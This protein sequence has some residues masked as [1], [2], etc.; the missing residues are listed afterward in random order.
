MNA[1]NTHI[2]GVT[3]EFWG[4]V[5]EMGISTPVDLLMNFP[6]KYND[7]T[8]PLTSLADMMGNC[9]GQYVIATLRVVKKGAIKRKKGRP[10][11]MT[12][13]LTDG[14]QNATATIFGGVQAWKD[15]K[16]LDFVFIRGKVDQWEGMVSFK[17]AMLIP[18][19]DHNRVAPVYTGKKDVMTPETLR[20]NT[21]L[22]LFSNVRDAV[23]HIE[24]EMGASEFDMR[25]E[26]DFPYPNLESYLMDVHMPVDV[27]S[28]EKIEKASQIINCYQLYN[29][30][31]H[32]HTLVRDMRSVIPCDEGLIQK[33]A[34]R[35]P[36]P[37]T[38]SQR[39]GIEEMA[40]LLAANEPMNAI[41]QGD[42]G[43]GKTVPYLTLAVMAYFFGKRVAIFIPNI[44]L[45]RQVADELQKHHSDVSINLIIDDEKHPKTYDG[46]SIV[47][48]TSAVHGWMKKAGA[49]HVFDFVIV[50]EQ[51]KMSVSQVNDLCSDYTN[52][53]EATATPVP[54][55]MALAAFG[56][57]K[58]FSLKECPVKKDIRSVLLTQKSREKIQ[59]K[60]IETVKNGDK[61]AIIY[62]SRERNEHIY[63][64][65]VPHA[66]LELES[67]KGFGAK[68]P[69]FLMPN[70]PYYNPKE[71][72]KL[73][74][75][76]TPKQ[77][78]VIKEHIST[79]YDDDI[80]SKKTDSAPY[81]TNILN[82]RNV[83]EAAKDWEKQFPGKVAKLHGGM[84]AKEKQEVIRKIADGTYSFIVS[85]TVIEVGM[86]FPGLKLLVTL[87]SDNYGCNTLHQLRGRIARDGG[88]GLFI[89]LINK[90]PS[91]LQTHSL[92]R[93]AVVRDTNDG[94]LLAE[95]DME[96]RGF[97]DLE[98]Q[99]L[100]QAG[101]SKGVISKTKITPQGMKG[102]IE[103][104]KIPFEPVVDLGKSQA[105]LL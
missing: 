74:L 58:I 94:T 12:V 43:F 26:V 47:I 72:I 34:S 52:L 78:K 56:N 23:K 10:A 85:T 76:A 55:T 6:K 81:L 25:K 69:Y 29:K 1:L 35:Y 82:K 24:T 105:I 50:D 21:Q 45:C 95:M 40:K 49:G 9:F 28:I 57:K 59:Q 92:E 87:D 77:A 71:G 70:D 30:I 27:D 41:L 89:M 104:L 11:M 83:E 80:K 100:K 31:K 84:K 8:K 42:V 75:I 91:T 73:N 39:E 46:Q 37:P 22:V 66:G 88:E 20:R 102:F 18:P 17:S 38:N 2:D 99:G 13:T 65:S 32:T 90:D 7:Y 93:L 101:Y 5:G 97:G 86:N 36:F 48:G 63:S 96:M 53:L 68:K 3:D 51:Q 54:R 61:A 98:K 64:F 14:L 15:V 103:S 16:S 4:A 33:I 79:Q 19:A 67:L 60:I 44:M 62:P